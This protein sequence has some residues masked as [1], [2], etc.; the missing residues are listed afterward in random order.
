MEVI[1]AQE[2]GFCFGVKRA[3]RL[4]EKALKEYEEVFSIGPLIHNQRVI[5]ELKKK[6]LRVLDSVSQVFKGP[7]II[8]SHGVTKGAFEE[9]KKRGI[10]IIDGTCP[11]VKKVQKLAQSLSRK[12]FLVVLIGEKDHAEVKG[13]L[14]Y[15]EGN[16]I[17]VESFQEI[18][19]GLPKRKIAV[20]IQTTQEPGRVKEILDFLFER[21]KEMNVYNTL[22]EAAQRR[23]KE[24]LELAKRV[25]LMFVI[26]GRESANTRRMVEVC[27]RVQARTYH[28]E[29]PEEIRPELLK[30]VKKVGLTGGASTP[31]HLIKEVYEILT[32]L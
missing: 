17:V 8:R 4:A 29:G 23:Q 3:L 27:K 18:P 12:G 16:A 26:G 6:G 30:M 5:D 32:A 28:I 11:N 10:K 20:L 24:A 19:E 31:P 25:D 15:T 2:A 13:I 1:I 14:S 22:C 21:I 7:V 9:L